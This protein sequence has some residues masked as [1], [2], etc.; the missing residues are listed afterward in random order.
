VEGQNF[1]YRKHVLEYDDVMNKQREAVYG[2]RRQLLEGEDQKE[3]LMGIADQIM[4]G[5]VDQHANAD[6]NPSEWDLEALGRAVMHQ[7]GFDMHAEGIDPSGLSSKEIED[8]LIEKAHQKYDEKEAIVGAPP[9]RFHE[10][11]I[12]LQFVD[13]QWKDHLLAMDHLKEGIGLRGYG[14]RDPLVEYKKESFTLFEDLMSRIEDDTIRFLF[15]LQPVDERKA[16]EEQER[17][18]RRQQ[19]LAAQQQTSAA[20][21][22]SVATQ[23]K[24]EAP[25]V[26]RNDPCPCGSGKKYKKC[27]GVNA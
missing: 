22:G 18:Q 25:K 26:G 23:V 6:A 20:S 10:R 15:L 2:L 4:A 9:M 12:M 7:F 27:H 8:R 17:R 13:A 5:L 11:M 3:Y 19:M 16:A 21:G 1:G 24:R 14:Q